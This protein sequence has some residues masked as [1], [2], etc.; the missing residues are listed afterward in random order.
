VRADGIYVDG[1]HS[2]GTQSTHASQ[3]AN[4]LALAYGAVPPERIGVVGRYVAGLG[5]S[6]GPVHGL[7]LLRGLASAG[8]WADM[9]RILTD[10]SVPGWARIV[11]GGGT[12]TWETWTPSDLIGDSLSH[13]WGS[14]ALVAMQES[15][16][17]VT[18]LKPDEAGTVRVAVA[19]PRQGL[20]RARGAVPSV[21]GPIS[22]EWRRERTE[23]TLQVVV[24]ANA[25]ARLSL[26]A[27]R[28]DAVRE[29]GASLA[30]AGGVTLVSFGDGVAVLET[31]S[32][33]YRFTALSG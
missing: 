33:S 30:Q 15:L 32:G 26:P 16:L 21:A 24:P 10:T 18:F 6:V 2:D 19:P 17:G 11:A 9:V 14:S 1:L 31:G 28:A 25:S 23:L 20:R 3:E 22:V 4:A 8:R 5:L 13:G 7:E 29:G 12:F 27:A